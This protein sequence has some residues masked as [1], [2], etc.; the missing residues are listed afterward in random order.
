MGNGHSILF[1]F[2]WLGHDLG[3]GLSPNLVG[4]NGARR[5]LQ[6]QVRAPEKN[7]VSKRAG[8]GPRAKTRGSGP[9]MEKPGLNPTRCHSYLEEFH[10]PVL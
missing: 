6:R 4:L 1:F 10:D 3:G 7:P 9:G 8:F 5:A 2:F